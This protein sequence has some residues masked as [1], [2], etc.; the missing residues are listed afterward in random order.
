MVCAATVATTAITTLPSASP[1]PSPST[2]SSSL[3]VAQTIPLPKPIIHTFPFGKQKDRQR[4]VIPFVEEDTT[5]FPVDV[6]TIGPFGITISIDYIADVIKPILLDNERSFE[7][8]TGD[9]C[10]EQKEEESRINIKKNVSKSNKSSKTNN[11]A[12][13]DEDDN[14]GDNV[15]DND[16]DDDSQQTMTIIEK[17]HL[18]SLM[19]I[20]KEDI[21]KLN[22][23][24]ELKQET[25]EQFICL[26]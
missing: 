23:S 3:E 5:T 2:S 4:I 11:N 6:V 8:S 22:E 16:G 21:D 17:Q 26:S 10:Q 9:E 24:I 20:D 18:S 13:N 7:M 19:L 14:V 1:S 25:I 12:N 15:D